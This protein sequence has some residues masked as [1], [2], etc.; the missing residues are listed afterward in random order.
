MNY[1]LLKINLDTCEEYIVDVFDNLDEAK[2]RAGQFKP[3]VQSEMFIQETDYYSI[4]WM[5]IKVKKHF[6]V[7]VVQ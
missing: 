6:E 4:V 3:S 1:E 2:G 5:G 7:E